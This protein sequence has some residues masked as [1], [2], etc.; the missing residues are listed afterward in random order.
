MSAV[1]HVLKS[2]LCCCLVSWARNAVQIS[3]GEGNSLVYRCRPAPGGPELER[4]CTFDTDVDA[5]G[6][7]FVIECADDETR[8]LTA[9][10]SGAGKD[11][12]GKR[13]LAEKPRN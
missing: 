9:G 4:R 10:P 5:W 8:V 12:V 11:V 3:R 13:P 7:P 1:A 6:Q 2:A